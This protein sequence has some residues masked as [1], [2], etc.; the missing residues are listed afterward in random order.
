MHHGHRCG[1][2]DWKNVNVSAKYPADLTGVE[3]FGW[4]YA[5]GAAGGKSLGITKPRR[6]QKLWTMNVW[7]DMAIP[8]IIIKMFWSGIKG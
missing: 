7:I 6:L 1:N 2:N 8:P 5:A 3:M 4:I